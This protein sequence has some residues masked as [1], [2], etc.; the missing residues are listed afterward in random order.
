MKHVPNQISSDTR[1]WNLV[2]SIGLLAYGGYGIYINDLWVPGRRR[3]GF[4]LSDEPALVMYAA[5][6]CGCLVLLS[7]VVDHYDRRNNEHKYKAFSDFFQVAAIGLFFCAIVIHL[8][9][10][11]NA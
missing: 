10:K 4:H 3:R 9:K 6:I 2:I 11:L 8:M 5:F 7:V 1:I